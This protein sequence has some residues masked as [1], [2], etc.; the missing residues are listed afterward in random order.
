MN[1]NEDNI[2]PNSGRSN[3]SPRARKAPCN[4]A[5]KPVQ[6]YQFTP[7]LTINDLRVIL[8]IGKTKAYDLVRS[9]EIGRV[10]VGGCIRIR[11]SEVM[12]YID[13]QSTDRNEEG[14]R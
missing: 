2:A 6:G 5:G 8:S 10:N 14:A 3:S 1:H 12:D 11:Y 7:L 9:R 4:Q 13:R